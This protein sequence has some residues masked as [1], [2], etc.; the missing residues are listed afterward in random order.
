MKKRLLKSSLILFLLILPISVST[1]FAERALKL[2]PESGAIDSSKRIA[3]IIGNSNYKT[4]PLKNPL[5]DAEDIAYELQ[6]LGFKVQLGKNMSKKDM[7]FAIREFGKEI[8]QGGV[9]LFYYAGHGMQVQGRNFL[10]PVGADIRTEDEV[11]YEAIDAGLILRKMEAAGNPMNIVMLDA[12]RDN[13]FAR[14]FRSAQ[15]GLAQ[16]DAPSGSLIVYATAP[17]SVAADGNGRNGTFTKNF[18]GHIRNPDLEVGQML[19]RVRAGVQKDTNGQQV[20]WESSSL[21]GDFYF[22][23]KNKEVVASNSRSTNNDLLDQERLKL[24]EEKRALAAEKS[25]FQ[26]E[27]LKKEQ[28]K[29]EEEKRKLEADKR[30]FQNQQL[31]KERL[32]LAEEKRKLAEEQQ[33]LAAE[34]QRIQVAKAAPSSQNR[35]YQGTKKETAPRRFNSSGRHL[36]GFQKFAPMQKNAKELITLVQNDLNANTGLTEPVRKELVRVL[37]VLKGATMKGSFKNTH[38]NMVALKSLAVTNQLGTAGKYEN[39]K[40]LTTDQS[41]EIARQQ[42]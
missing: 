9:G 24:E 18:L 35:S 6:R 36:T 32:A 4:S 25:R 29:L 27:Q 41:I 20:P 31:E 19:K 12:C 37:S 21:V 15:K 16:M 5:N 38:D 26:D 8:K 11:E 22:V 23:E 14:S 1:V 7:F 17:G 2:V 34:K 13:P 3:L 33:R 42:N 30:K 28:T 40:V 10:I 39:F